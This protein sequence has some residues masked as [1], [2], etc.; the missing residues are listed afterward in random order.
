MN[1]FLQTIVAQKRAEVTAAAHQR[2]IEALQAL[3]ADRHDHRSL[4]AALAMD[5]VRIMAEIKR[6]SP[7]LGPIRLDL[8]PACL[9]RAY[10]DGGAAALSVLTETAFF[11]GSIDDLQAARAVTHLPVLRKDFILTAYQV[12]ESAACGADAILLIVRILSDDELIKL[13]SLARSL[14]LDVLVEIHNAHDA[15]RAGRLGAQLI[16]INNRD[17]AQFV[18]DPD[19]ARR[20]AGSFTADTMLVAA[21]GIATVAD[22]Q[23]HL[24]IGIRRFLIGECLVRS[25]D[26]ASLLRKF[27]G[28]ALAKPFTEH[29]LATLP[30]PDNQPMVAEGG[31]T[32]HHDFACKPAET[33]IVAQSNRR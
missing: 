15:E 21:S 27:T 3:A 7:S 16:G 26:P 11:K 19:N 6:A 23:R 5:G 20:L 25:S 14:C 22:I 31:A 18:T 29:G 28:A 8:D 10:T 32:R 24:T 30:A 33:G 12:I 4:T 13:Q 1:T 2:P 9:A 17:L